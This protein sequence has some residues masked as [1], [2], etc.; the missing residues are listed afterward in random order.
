MVVSRFI[1]LID[2]LC[3]LLDYITNRKF[4]LSRVTS[5]FIT[6]YE[7]DRRTLRA[8]AAEIYR[9]TKS[10]RL[11]KVL[12]AVAARARSGNKPAEEEKTR[13][14]ERE[15]M[16][17]GKC[18]MEQNAKKRE[19]GRAAMKRGASR[20]GGQP[21]VASV[22]QA[23]HSSRSRLQPSIHATGNFIF[24]PWPRSR[25]P[26]RC[27]FTCW[28]PDV[29]L[30]L[31]QRIRNIDRP[32]RTRPRREAEGGFRLSCKTWATSI[33]WPGRIITINPAVIEGG[34]ALGA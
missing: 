1:R 31:P 32:S 18:E 21:K 29:S 5:P 22:H 13:E 34:G 28:L 17:Q 3:S 30:G 10:E 6:R 14:K 27:Y 7:I 26:P 20:P 24:F 16:I 12:P 2:W 19:R 23:T 25:G 15:R 4:R 8:I 11:F 9:L 33:T